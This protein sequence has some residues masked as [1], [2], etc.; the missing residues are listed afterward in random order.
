MEASVD[1]MVEN[2]CSILDVRRCPLFQD[3]ECHGS[4]VRWTAAEVGQ[5]VQSEF[6]S[7]WETLSSHECPDG[8]NRWMELELVESNRCFLKH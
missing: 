8:A 6:A 4:M 2:C 7:R 3:S 1:S 5:P